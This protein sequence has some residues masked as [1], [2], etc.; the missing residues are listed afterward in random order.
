[1]APKITYS[2]QTKIDSQKIPTTINKQN[3]QYKSNAM[4][5]LKEI[6]VGQC[7]LWQRHKRLLALRSG[8]ATPCNG[9]VR[10]HVHAGVFVLVLVFSCTMICNKKVRP[11]YSPIR[12]LQHSKMDVRDLV[13]L[14]LSECTMLAAM[15]GCFWFAITVTLIGC[16]CEIHHQ[17][18]AVLSIEFAHVRTHCR[19]PYYLLKYYQRSASSH[20]TSRWAF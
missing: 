20:Q 16:T 18:A 11:I 1:M 8:A 14:V 13:R 12:Y 3:S 19:H 7:H 6:A 15:P 2:I 4:A 10:T 9:G 5:R 17:G